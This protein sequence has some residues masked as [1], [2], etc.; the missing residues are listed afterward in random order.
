MG[1]LQ[2]VTQA[3]H[4]GIHRILELIGQFLL[5]LRFFHCHSGSCFRWRSCRWWLCCLHWSLCLFFYRLFWLLWL[6]WFLRRFLCRL[7]FGTQWY[8]RQLLNWHPIHRRDM[9]RLD[10]CSM[11]SLTREVWL[12]LILPRVSSLFLIEF[13]SDPLDGGVQR[14]DI[15]DCCL[16]A[17]KFLI[18]QDD[19]CSNL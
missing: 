2:L 13:H 8:F 3:V 1:L 19:P 15:L 11:V 10:K 14:P 4:L 12:A 9:H 7:L 18:C 5:F 6:C 17:I 16:H